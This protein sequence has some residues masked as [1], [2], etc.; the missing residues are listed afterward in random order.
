MIKEVVLEEMNMRF[1]WQVKGWVTKSL[2][3]KKNAGVL[4]WKYL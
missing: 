4:Q 1:A 2:F 3:A